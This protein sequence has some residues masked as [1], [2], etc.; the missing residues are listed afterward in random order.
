MKNTF[1]KSIIYLGL[2]LVLL[3]IFSCS[4]SGSSANNNFTWTYGNTNYKANFNA[5]Y[6]QS[7]GGN[8][9][10]VAGTGAALHTLA[11]GPRFTVS[12]LNVGTYNF[13]TSPNSMFYIEDQ[14]NNLAAVT[15]T[16]NITSNAG[17]LLSGNFSATLS[18]SINVTGSFMN[19]PI[20]Q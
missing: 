11:I 15:G 17:N 20:N 13:N 8:P 9:I 2:S 10:I 3:N 18:N 1:C 4:K 19:V 7:L 14:G 16:I 6:L 12:S 5:A